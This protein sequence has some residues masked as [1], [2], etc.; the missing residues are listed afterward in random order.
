MSDAGPE[1]QSRRFLSLYALASAGGAIAYV[2]FLTILF[3]I[4]VSRL[5]GEE[6]IAWLAY[7][8]FAGAVT[9]SLAS[10]GF[11]WLSDRTGT[12]RL[13]IAIGLMVSC[14][15]LIGFAR[16]EGMAG[17][18]ILLIGW[19]AALNMML[20]PLSA[21]AGDCVPDA[22]KGR[23]GGLLAFAPACGALAG[24]VVTLPGLVAAEYRLWLVAALVCA[25][26]LPALVFARPRAMPGLMTDEGDADG[27]PA[28][29]RPRR[30]VVRMWLA[31]LLMQI[32]EAALFAYI[33][34]WLR[35]ID[36]SLGEASVAQIF[37]S[38]LMGAVPVA[39]L[40]G[41]WADRSD[42]PFAPLRLATV[43]AAA[44]LVI[45][46]L[47]DS[48]PMA[49]AG[50]VVFGLAAGVFL[51]LHTAQTLRV[52][53]RPSRRGRDMGIFNLTNTG[54]TLIVPWITLA[55]VPNFGFGAL[56]A[57]L[58]VCALLS[59]LLLARLSVRP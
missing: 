22:Q 59:A 11:G 54:P 13:W 35:D 10:I 26:V 5:A 3:P 46:A 28:P 25:C 38:V 42:R 43:I 7:C 39:I 23:L 41:R 17:A 53:P 32:S 49:V 37:G 8:S 36:P 16:V 14:L 4:Q 55:V 47:A 12:R 18:I 1:R 40:A 50:Y 45:M 2:P 56:F 6:A 44:G 51:A 48:L 20:G 9:A 52:L 58:A 31:R 21:W 57:I 30:T 19:Q 33:Y 24:A 27:Q 15:L 29:A 34:L